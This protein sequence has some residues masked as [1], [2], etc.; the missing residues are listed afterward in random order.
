M[1]LAICLGL[2]V[3]SGGSIRGR[4]G[5]LLLGAGLGRRA[6]EEVFDWRRHCVRP[7]EMCVVV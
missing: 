1:L 3:G 2:L 7:R 6:G 4:I 5:G